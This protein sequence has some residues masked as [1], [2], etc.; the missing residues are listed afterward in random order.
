MCMCMNTAIVGCWGKGTNSFY[1]LKQTGLPPPPH[2][3]S[4]LTLT[5]GNATVSEFLYCP[6]YNEPKENMFTD[7]NQV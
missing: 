5:P 4:G 3:R 6:L 7:S 2:W 1:D